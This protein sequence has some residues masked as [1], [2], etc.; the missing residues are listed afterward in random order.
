MCSSHCC[1]GTTDSHLYATSMIQKRARTIER[2]RLLLD[3]NRRTIERKQ[4]TNRIPFV[5]EGC[6]SDM[7]IRSPTDLECTNWMCRR[8]NEI[9]IKTLAYQLITTRKVIVSAN[10]KESEKGREALAPTEVQLQVENRDCSTKTTK[11]SH[12]T[13]HT[14]DSKGHRCGC[15]PF[16]R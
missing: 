16:E 2:A 3:V 12:R 1:A 15:S 4:C 8:A 6:A 14:K 5:N 11:K 10:E 13:P 7:Q 9:Q